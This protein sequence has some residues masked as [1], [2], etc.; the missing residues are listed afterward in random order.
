MSIRRKSD[1][2]VNDGAPAHNVQVVKTALNIRFHDQW[3]ANQGPFHWPARSPDLT[4]LD[5]F[6]WGTIKDKVYARPITTKENL[7]ERVK[8]AFQSLT[9]N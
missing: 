6:I 1:W 9:R 2:Y 4:P 7:I 3:I 5:F 8:A